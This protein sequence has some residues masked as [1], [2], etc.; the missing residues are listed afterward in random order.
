VQSGPAVPAQIPD[1]KLTW[2]VFATAQGKF[3]W[4]SS[5]FATHTVLDAG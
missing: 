5:S 3:L 4:A 1:A 2:D